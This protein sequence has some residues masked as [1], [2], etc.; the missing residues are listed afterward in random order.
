MACS[1]NLAAVIDLEEIMINLNN[2]PKSDFL[3]FLRDNYPE[4]YDKV[5]A[6]AKVL[7]NK[8]LQIEVG[9]ELFKAWEDFDNKCG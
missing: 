6:T 5:P 2:E 4:L 9:S 3:D 8:E 7:V 1:G